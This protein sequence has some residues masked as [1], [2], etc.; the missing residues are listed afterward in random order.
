MEEVSLINTTLIQINRIRVFRNDKPIYLNY[1]ISK[2]CSKKLN[3]FPMPKLKDTQNIS[4]L[5]KLE[6]FLGE[7]LIKLLFIS[8]AWNNVS[9]EELNQIVPY[10]HMKSN[11]VFQCLEYMLYLQKICE[12][13]KTLGLSPDETSKTS[14]NFGHLVYKT[15]QSMYVTLLNLHQRLNIEETSKELTYCKTYFQY[16][17]QA[18][19]NVPIMNNYVLYFTCIDSFKKL[20][21]NPIFRCIEF[22]RLTDSLTMNDVIKYT[23]VKGLESLRQT[24]RECIFYLFHDFKSIAN[25]VGI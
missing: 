24:L 17:F 20:Y 16:F 18:F 25:L 7:N 14:E 22:I 4:D 13:P 6:E 10:H 5:N 8:S 15:L 2:Q 19:N 23:S 12:R 1:T 3:I 21:N 9:I 11:K